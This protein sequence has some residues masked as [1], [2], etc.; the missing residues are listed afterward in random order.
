MALSDDA[1]YISST[2]EATTPELVS[3]E[4]DQIYPY[5]HAFLT[6]KLLIETSMRAPSCVS[7]NIV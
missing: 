2:N 7:A 5:T 1:I 3:L 6:F 4:M